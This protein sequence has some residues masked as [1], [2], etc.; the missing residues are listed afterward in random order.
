MRGRLLSSSAVHNRN[1]SGFLNDR[2]LA[3][4]NMLYICQALK[5]SSRQQISE[6]MLRSVVVGELLMGELSRLSR[7]LV[8][9]TAGQRNLKKFGRIKKVCIFAA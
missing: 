5:F 1:F 2:Q 4:A 3:N 6:K 8:P 7:C 9:R